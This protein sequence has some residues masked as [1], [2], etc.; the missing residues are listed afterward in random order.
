MRNLTDITPR[1]LGDNPE[2]AVLHVLD[3][4]LDITR[5]VLVAAHPQLN[6]GDPSADPIDL[7]AF[8]ARNVIITAHALQE[9]LGLYRDATS[10]ESRWIRLATRQPPDVDF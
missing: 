8:A 10:A 1:E 6:T 2:L 9:V 5:F 3:R 7:E 4:V